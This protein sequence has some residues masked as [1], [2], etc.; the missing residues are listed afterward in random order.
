MKSFLGPTMAR[1]IDESVKISKRMQ[2]NILTIEHVFFALIHNKY[3]MQILKN[4]GINQEDLQRHIGQY[5]V[6][7]VPIS[8]VNSIPEQ[9][10]ALQRVFFNMINHAKINQQKQLDVQDFLI[11]MLEEE[12]SYSALLLKSYEVDRGL[13]LEA[14]SQVAEDFQEDPLKKYAQNLNLLA[15]KGKIDPIIGREKEIERVSEILC[16]RKKNNAILIGEPGVGKTAIAEGIALSIVQKTCV[17]ALNNF[18][19]YSL[20]LA[21]MVAGSKYRG[22]FEKRLKSVVESIQEQENIILFIDEIHMIVGAGATG[23]N[24]NMDAANILKPLL[25]SGKLRCI[26]A[27]TFQEYKNYF[28]KDRA[29]SRRFMSVEVLEPSIEDCYKILQRVAPL[30]EDYHQV[31]YS[32]EAIRACVDLSHAYINERFLPDKA[33]D[34]LDESG[35]NLEYKKH[36]NIEKKQI[37]DTLA[38]FVNIPREVLRSDEK[39]LLQRLEKTLQKEVFSQNEAI[40]KIVSAIKINKA[41]LGE[42][43]KPIGSFLFVG[44]SGVGKTSLAQNLSQALGIKFYRIDMSEYMEAHSVAKLIGSPNGYVG[45]EQGGMLV[46]MIRKNPHC[47][48]LLD[49]IEKAH[50]DIYNLLL[51]VMDD[52]SLRDNLG[53][54]ADFRNVILIMTSN[55]GTKETQ[56]LGF[57]ASMQDK[58]SSAIKDLFS[59]EFRGRLDGVIYFNPLNKKDYINIAKKQIVL[60]NKKL[61]EKEISLQID[62]KALDFIAS[63][64]LDPMLGARE[65]ANIINTQIKP[66]LSEMIL[67]EIKDRPCKLKIT[68]FQNQLK[69]VKNSR[70]KSD[71]L[72]VIEN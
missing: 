29:L 45:F 8:E 18:E 56:K 70:S 30:Y 26:G 68:L 3:G 12:Q 60:L 32:D 72:I 38:K 23:N 4:C 67:F 43:D 41:G 6:K 58:H 46:D 31:K 48:L 44:P 2:H 22:D 19:I 15:K 33:I 65:I 16:K 28:L 14:A 27:T 64:A 55:A 51:Q 36:R 50:S 37:E 21:G 66:K 7:H 39:Q 25:S 1:I 34:L 10:P 13:I 17:K 5:L 42:L 40:A 9:T 61:K 52:A 24:G 35:V 59:P 57:N 53:N 54:K 71:R 63:Y 20:D 11:F 62:S 47:V 49:E 69:I